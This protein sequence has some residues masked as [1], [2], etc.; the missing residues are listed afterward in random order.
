MTSRWCCSDKSML[1]EFLNMQLLQSMKVRFVWTKSTG[2]AMENDSADTSCKTDPPPKKFF[3]GGGHKLPLT[4]LTND[5]S[6][7]L[8]YGRE[9]QH[10]VQVWDPLSGNPFSELLKGCLP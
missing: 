2:G 4:L 10:L 5:I 6:L 9:R 8:L 1:V 3:A 7:Y